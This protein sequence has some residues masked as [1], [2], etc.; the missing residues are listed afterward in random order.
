MTIKRY[1]ANK[2][3]TITNAFKSNNITRA[4]NANMGGSDILEVYSIYGQVDETSLEK[5]RI[6]IQFP[7]EKI[8]ED[9]NTNIIGASGSCQ[10]ILKLSNAPNFYSTPE[11]I[12]LN[13]FQVSGSWLEG[14]GL[15][16]EDYSDIG[17][18]NWISS[19]K[20]NGWV[21]QGGDYFNDFIETTIVEEVDDLEVDITSFV[22]KWLDGTVQNNGLIIKLTSSLED[23]NESYFTK[24]FFGRKSQFFFK[25]PYIEARS[26]NTIKDDRYNFYASSTALSYEDNLNTLYLFNRV[27]GALK[28]LD[29]VGTGTLIVSLHSGDLSTGPELQSL[30]LTNGYVNVTGGYV[31][32]GIYTAS[33]GLSGNYE[34]IWDIWRD[35]SGNILHTGSAIELKQR[36]ISESIDAEQYNLTMPNLKN[37]YNLNEVPKFRVVA[38]DKIWNA[39]LFDLARYEPQINIIE[40]LYFKINRIVDNY[41]VIPY[42][43]GS[44]Q[45]TLTS[46]DKSGNYFDLDLKLLEP[47][48]SYKISFLQKIDDNYHEFKQTFKFRVE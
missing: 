17:V 25:R 13:I 15:D 16:M 24:M 10:F 2:D 28:N 48:Y 34:Y 7:I 26:Y 32:T 40:N 20:G 43:T 19:S 45:H 35:A 21:T 11:N 6:L 47:G 12:K 5:S 18:S 44:M 37:I 4:T 42:G 22:E 14:V 3:N 36:M 30:L 41:E 46:Y 29:T 33:L 23:G 1:V 8:A 31:S 9:R 38:K 39:N 27:N